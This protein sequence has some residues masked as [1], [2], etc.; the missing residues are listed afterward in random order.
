MGDFVGSVVGDKVGNTVGAGNRDPVGDSVGDS[1]GD[2]VGDPVGD[3]VGTGV[4]NFVL[5]GAPVK[6]REAA[7]DGSLLLVGT[8]V[9][10][11]L[12][13]SFDAPFGCALA[14]PVGTRVGCVLDAVVVGDKLGNKLGVVIENDNEIIVCKK[15]SSLA[16]S[17]AD[18]SNTSIESSVEG[19]SNVTKTCRFLESFFSSNPK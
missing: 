15:R 5:V 9:G 14:D 16:C 11:A 13:K 7:T 1:V 19:R 18:I 10:D 6:G 8:K 2:L 4:G 3:P 17:S 12:G